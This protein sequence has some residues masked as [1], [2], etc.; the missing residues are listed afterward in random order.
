MKYR[1]MVLALCSFFVF[2]THTQA[3]FRNVQESPNTALSLTGNL[4]YDFSREMND[5]IDADSIAPVRKTVYRKKYSPLRA[6]L[7]SAVIPGTG[8]FYTKSYWQSAAFFGAEV[9]LWIG[10]AAY[11]NSGDRKTEEFQKYADEHWSVI[12]YAYWIQNSAYGSTYNTI[13]AGTPIVPNGDPE[14]T[15]NPWNYVNWN[16]LNTCEETIG[17]L[18]VTDPTNYPKGTG[19]THKLEQ[20]G[21]Q[22]YYEMIGKYAQFGGGWDDAATFKADA[23][24]FSSLDLLNQNVSPR[25]KAYSNMRGEANDKYTIARTVSYL[26]VANHVLSALE[27]AWNASKINNRIKLQGH[28]QSRR[29]MG[30]N[31]V[32]FVPTLQ[33]ECE[34]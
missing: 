28:I 31:L 26:I 30:G 1:I 13:N 20:H 33:F 15:P 29:V 32:E 6:G 22:Q 24:V 3:Q 16:A 21:Q 18:S 8:Q 11:E 5:N 12:R 10:Y 2:C 14:N 23:S 7:F 4:Q 25:F 9:L 17:N 34:L 19:F 27:A